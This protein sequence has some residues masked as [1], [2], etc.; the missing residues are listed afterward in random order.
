MIGS[1]N[2]LLHTRTNSTQDNPATL[3]GVQQQ[4][5]HHS[6]GGPGAS[7]LNS[8]GPQQEEADLKP[9]GVGLGVYRI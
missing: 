2:P 7:F 1:V 6:I 8:L 5:K 3:L 4:K 9:M